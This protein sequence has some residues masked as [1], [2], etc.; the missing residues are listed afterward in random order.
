MADNKNL[1]LAIL[2]S[3]L[4]VFGYQLIFGPIT[5]P[6]TQPTEQAGTEPPASGAPA[7]APAPAAAPAPGTAAA[8]PVQS[9]EAAI[10]AGPRL[11]VRTKRLSGSIALKGAKFDDLALNDYREQVDPKS[12]KIELLSPAGTGNAYFAQFGWVPS[13]TVA[14]PGA[15]T[16]WQASADVLEPGKPVTLSWDN[17]QGLIFTQTVAVDDDFMF[18]VAQGVENKGAAAVAVHAYG[19]LS[20]HGTPHTSGYA[21]MHEGLLGVFDGTLKEVSYSDIK[22]KGVEKQDATGGWLGITDK[23]WL[24]ALA[25]AQTARV[26][27]RLVHTR[28]GTL[29]K[30][31]ADLLGEKLS[32]EPGAKAETVTHFFAGAKEVKL[33]D[34]YAESLGIGRFDLAID[35]GWFYFLTKP[36][37]YLLI[38]IHQYI[39][40]F[41][42]AILALTVLIKAA[43]FPLANKSYS[44]MSKMKKLQPQMEKLRERFGEDKM[45]LNQEMMALYKREK[46]NPAAG[47]LPILVQIPVFFALYKVLFVTI[48]MRHAPF[49]GWIHDLSAPDPTTIF[50]LFGLIPWAPPEYLMIGIW[51]IIMGV[52]M[53][54]QQKLNPQPTDPIQAKIFLVLP[55]LFTF[56][57]ATFPAGLVIYWA[58]NNVLSIAQQWI[59]MK[60]EGV[61]VNLLK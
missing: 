17:G 43:M 51:P 33:L 47:C 16:V 46:V 23:Y 15:D 3:F 56:L 54:L 26:A 59:I 20:R 55:F 58:W 4:I 35:F 11:K 8:Q 57:L 44:A 14:V 21:I 12:A 9:R 2:L 52:T 45:R 25:P 60:K 27:T 29:D 24:T 42:I 10:T 40:N 50:N 39:P 31:Q 28:D 38:V 61:E 30:Y 5:P 36:I 32:L 7:T 6:T 49:Y 18:T 19:L 37:F 41:G 48:E 1:I 13:G 53:W 22:D 34:K